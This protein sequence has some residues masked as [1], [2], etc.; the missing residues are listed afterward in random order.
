[1]NSANEILVIDGLSETEIVLRAV[2]EPRGVQVN[3]IRSEFPE[4]KRKAYRPDVVIIHGNREALESQ[5]L[6]QHWSNA[7]SIYLEENDLF[8][9]DDLMQTIELMLAERLKNCSVTSADA[10]CRDEY[11]LK[12]AA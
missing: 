10:A 6:Q 2:W 12:S 5:E 3:R 11:D 9:Y 7:D 1:M 4:Q 8:Q